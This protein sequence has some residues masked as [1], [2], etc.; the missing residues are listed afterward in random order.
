VTVLALAHGFRG[1][2]GQDAYAYFDYATGPL[3]DALLSA[4]PPPPFSF[5]PGYP[6]LIT[7]GSFIVGATPVIGQAINIVAGGLTALLTALLAREVLD[8]SWPTTMLSLVPPVAGLLV[9]LNGQLWQSSVV[10]MSDA[11]ALAAAT[12]GIL[13]LARYGKWREGRWLWLAGGALAWAVLVRLVYGVVAIPATLYAFTILTQQPL[14]RRW[15][16]AAGAALIV[17]LILSPMIYQIVTAI[18]TP[19]GGLAGNSMYSEIH[20]WSPLTAFRSEHQTADGLLRYQWPNGLYYAAIPFRSFYLTPIFA[21]LL[22]PGLWVLARGR[23]RV[24]W[25]VLAWVAILYLFHAGTAWQ[26]P[27]FTLAYLPPLAILAA[28]GVGWLW[29][30]ATGQSLGRALVSLIVV[31]G[32]LWMAWGA[33]SLTSNFIA[34]MQE[35]VILVREVESSLPPDSRLITFEFALTARHESNLEV[36]QIFF[37][38]PDQMR[39]LL[40]DDRATYLLLDVPATESQWAGRAPAQNYEWLRDGPGL[41]PIG[42]FGSYTLFAVGDPGALP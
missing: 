26:N 6:I 14:R 30:R 1:L 10:V 23:G 8:R 34:R 11:V 4:Q 32:V 13:A 20:R 35:N 36:H 9:A 21:L 29:E 31:V 38:T 15:S 7:A 27:R 3:R 19:E 33:W 37:L 22:L 2:Y 39:D 18:T 5:P 41:E 12:L 28:L 40:E 24:R 17:I 25:L 16:H 42:E